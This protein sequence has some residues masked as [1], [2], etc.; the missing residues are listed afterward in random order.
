MFRTEENKLLALYVGV[1]LLG[2]VFAT[3]VRNEEITKKL[4]VERCF[5]LRDTTEALNLD[6]VYNELI[7]DSIEHPEVVIRQIILETGFL[8]SSVCLDSNN[9]FGFYTDHYIKYDNWKQSIKAYKAYQIKNYHNGNYYKFLDS[10]GYA[11]DTSYIYKLK[12]IV[13]PRD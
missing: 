12:H 4:D 10:I 13:W 5:T 9:L 7:L 2:V 11:N 8:T 3:V 1:L 6:N